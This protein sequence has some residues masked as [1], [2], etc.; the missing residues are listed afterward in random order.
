MKRQI[1]GLHDAAQSGD[2]CQLEGLFLVRVERGFYRWHP[3]KPFFVIRF[4]MLQPKQNAGQSFSGRL[5]STPRALWKL[6]WFLRDFGYDADLLGRDEVDEKT[7]IGLQGVV[8]ISHVT[9]NGH[10]FLNLDG[11]A[12]AEE[13]EELAIT[14][15][16]ARESEAMGDDF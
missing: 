8:R 3:R 1:P 16:P 2:S 4:S 12:P 11:F 5:Y 9:V 10:S 15:A 13:W 6:H 7:L 14:S